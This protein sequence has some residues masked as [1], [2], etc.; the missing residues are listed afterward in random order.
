[1][2]RKIEE[3]LLAWKD[4]TSNRLPLI[5]NGARQVG[6]T[7]ILRKFGGEQFKNVVYINLETNLAVASY[8][9]DNI[10]PE[11]L[12]R[13]LEASTGERIV[14]GE[15]LVILDEIQSCERALTSL[16]YF[17]EETPEY[18]IVAAG[19]LLGV[20]INRQRYSF[21]VGKVETIT[22]HPLDFEEFLWAR[23]KEVLCEEIRRAYETMEPLPDALHQEAIELYREYLLI[24]GMPAC[25]NAFLNSGSFLDVP[26]VQN[27]ILDN[28]IADM[29]KYASNT[30]SVKIRACYNSIPA[31]LAKD[32]KK[33]QYKVVQKGGSAALFGA[34]IEWLNL[35]GVV[36][37]C[38]RINQAY[39][40]IAVY[41]DLSAFKLY[42]GDVGLLT[43]KSGI[44]QQTVLSGEGN[45]FMGAITENYVAQQLAA[46]GYDLYYW[47]SSNTA[48]L[49]FV[50]QK[51]NQIV[52]IEVKKGEHVRSRSLSVFANSYKPSYSVRLSLK[53]FGEKDRLKA[54][55]L[56]AVFCI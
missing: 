46:K 36:L 51:D 55:P 38:Q 23:G 28:Y 54:I 33:F 31:Q 25:I 35:A 47:E 10:T 41:A 7:Y 3:R 53:N 42:M 1:M 11:R 19:S 16:K 6:K 15:T 44:S 39:E 37:K 26:L 2:K 32:N 24:G 13:Y 34:S 8:F 52:G 40:P 5:V 48:E 27:E 43:M 18:H 14:P 56:Y 21:P 4:K 30:D 20:A 12:L 17:C 45:I 9:N 49:D 29:A 22:L 50:L